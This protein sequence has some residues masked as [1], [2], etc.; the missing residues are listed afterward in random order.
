MH[1]TSVKSD[2]E[3]RK[4]SLQLGLELMTTRILDEVLSI[5]NHKDWPT[6]CVYLWMAS[7]SHAIIFPFHQQTAESYQTTT[8]F[9]QSLFFLARTAIYLWTYNT[10]IIVNRYLD[11]YRYHNYDIPN[12]FSNLLS[13][14]VVNLIITD[15]IPIASLSGSV[16]KEFNEAAKLYRT[17]G[18]FLH[19][20]AELKRTS[21]L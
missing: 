1:W 3:R 8:L 7:M 10:S 18:L 15:I 13:H 4:F 5:M 12:W 16:G 21:W 2:V 6:F 20:T 19:L 17:W 9:A 11:I 14:Q